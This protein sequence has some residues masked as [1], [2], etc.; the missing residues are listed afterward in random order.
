MKST[1]Y[2]V[3]ICCFLFPLKKINVMDHWA[4]AECF[5]PSAFCARL[6][7]LSENSK[8][9]LS[10]SLQFLLLFWRVSIRGVMDNVRNDA[11]LHS[12]HS[13]V[14]LIF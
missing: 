2:P 7:L 8:G 3:G 9:V 11:I 14:S 12:F 4:A 10:V 13:I 1:V 5:S 6:Y